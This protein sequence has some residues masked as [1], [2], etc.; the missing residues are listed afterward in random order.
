M[1]HRSGFVAVVVAA[2]VVVAPK[3]KKLFFLMVVTVPSTNRSKT[4]DFKD[5]LSL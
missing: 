1:K 5:P 4:C 3:A 2:A